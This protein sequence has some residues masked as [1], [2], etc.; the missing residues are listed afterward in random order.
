MTDARPIAIICA[1]PTR[2]TMSIETH[3]CLTNCMAS[4]PHVEFVVARKPVDDA[5]NILA[6]AIRS[7]NDDAILSFRAPYVLW[8]D[9]DS[10]WTSEAVQRAIQYLDVRPEID[11]LTGFYSA[12]L[13]NAPPM[14][15]LKEP[16]EARAHPSMG[17][18]VEIR[19]A[20]FHWLWMR[21]EVLDKLGDGPFTIEG[22]GA[23]LEDAA[24]FIRAQSVGLRTF[25]ATQL[26]IAHI[27]ASTGVG[28]LPDSPALLSDGRRLTSIIENYVP[29]IVYRDYGPKVNASI[30]RVHAKNRSERRQA[31]RHAKGAGNS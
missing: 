27:E 18:L 15:F 28:Y 25:C 17:E 14:V 13:P 2:G 1:I 30:A 6:A 29:E 9:D 8:C 12:R 24:F 10:M 31:F 3:H 11:I 5:R 22:T 7:L 4:L 20:S 19:T 21:R 26:V 16:P 23:L